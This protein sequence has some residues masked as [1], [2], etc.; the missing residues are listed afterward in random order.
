MVADLLEGEPVVQAAGHQRRHA[1]AD[2][3]DHEDETDCEDQ[4]RAGIG[5][6]RRPDGSWSWCAYLDLQARSCCR[7]GVRHS[8]DEKLGD[9]DGGARVA[10]RLHGDREGSAA[11]DSRS[12]K[13]RQPCRY[14]VAALTASAKFRITASEVTL[15]RWALPAAAV[16]ARLDTRAV[17]VS[18]VMMTV[19]KT[20][21]RLSPVSVCIGASQSKDLSMVARTIP[22]PPARVTGTRAGGRG[23]SCRRRWGLRRLMPA[24]IVRRQLVPDAAC[25]PAAAAT[26]VVTAAVLMSTPDGSV[27]AAGTVGVAVTAG[28]AWWE[29]RIGREVD[30]A[31]CLRCVRRRRTGRLRALAGQVADTNDHDSRQDADQHDRDQDFD[32]CETPIVYSV[33]IGA[34]VPSNTCS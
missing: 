11:P 14:S 21:K 16:F 10:R 9:R 15:R 31:A 19:I 29:R 23:F 26:G 1:G 6:R 4:R 18:P 34:G 30:H 7:T 32:E 2:R 24:V 25:M 20:S 28:S 17:M 8:D 27:S 22:K 12:C 3:A 33:C 5:V 13:G